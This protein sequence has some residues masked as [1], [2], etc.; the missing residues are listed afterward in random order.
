M[1]RVLRD[2][3]ETIERAGGRSIAFRDGGRRHRRV[4]FLNA[5]GEPHEI[6]IHVGTNGKRFEDCFRSQLRRRG[7]KP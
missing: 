7:L 6:T 3:K 4:S 2:I 1:I 5:D